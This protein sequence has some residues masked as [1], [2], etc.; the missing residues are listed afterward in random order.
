M[1]LKLSF[2]GMLLLVFSFLQAQDSHHLNPC[3][4]QDGRVQWLKDYQ[5]APGLFPRSNDVLYV[6]VTVHIVG[7]S[8]GTGYFQK[9]GVLDAFCTLNEDFEPAGIQFFIE[10]NIRYHNNS[11]WYDHTFQQGSQMMNQK[12]V[13]N[14]INCYIVGSPA[15]N[16][17]YSSYNQG[18]A[19]AKNCISPS[20]HTW[21]H[22][23]GHYLSLPHPFD[24][25]E[26]E[27]FD[28]NQPA[29]E[30]IN[31]HE[32]ERLDGS[33]CSDAGDGFCDTP[34]DYLNYRWG[35]DFQNF[36]TT[37]QKDPTGAEFKSDGTLF[38]SY[39]LDAC[40]D[41]FSGDQ[42]AAMQANLMTERANLLYN[43]TPAGPVDLTDFTVVSPLQDDTIATFQDVTFEWLEAPNAEV[44]FLEV[45]VI[46]NFQAVLF[47]YE[48]QGT[49][50]TTNDLKKNK[51]Y[52]WRVRAYNRWHTC[53]ELTP[54]YSFKTGDV[55]TVTAVNAI[56]SIEGLEIFP[57]PAA[58]GSEVFV[59]FDATEAT[60]L[61]VNLLN[62]SGQAV[63]R[64]QK[65]V[66]A[67]HQ[68]FSIPTD[69]LPAGLYFIQMRTEKGVLSRKLVVGQ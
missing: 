29:P 69:R 6:P 36:S 17:G 3:G 24:G 19:L 55:E 58:A 7:K 48:V 65:Q 25:W 32:V 35:C 66:A 28:Y 37:T 1:K 53:K 49:S 64:Q 10:G 27:D 26:N 15:G 8:D 68:V 9:T 67:G 14:T 38:M 56:D 52:Y 39:A 59:K 34:A 31:G 11:T 62:L 51:T 47:R 2:S 13:P 30:Y 16:C 18:I 41:R 40:A 46:A 33:N 57:N 12:N 22:E 4:T 50:F 23:V 44:Y 42:I 54:I 60:P 61:E 5:K 20:D 63:Y 43:Q 45:T 21:A